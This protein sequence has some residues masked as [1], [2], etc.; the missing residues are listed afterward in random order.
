MSFHKYL[1]LSVKG[2]D[3][4]KMIRE[5]MICEIAFPQK[6][7]CGTQ[8]PSVQKDF[9]RGSSGAFVSSFAL[10]SFKTELLFHYGLVSLIL[11]LIT[12]TCLAKTLLSHY[13]RR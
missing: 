3:D 2:Y 11:H 5:N 7:T 1:L 13:Y 6:N 10:L 12:N 9:V 4:F 8:I